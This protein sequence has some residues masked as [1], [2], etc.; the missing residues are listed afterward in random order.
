[1]DAYREW[2]VTL[3]DEE[4]ENERYTVTHEARLIGMSDD[5]AIDKTNAIDLETGNRTHSQFV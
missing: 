4:F 1:M 5:E 3:T 2:L